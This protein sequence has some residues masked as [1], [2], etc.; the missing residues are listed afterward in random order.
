M[1]VRPSLGVLK[2]KER[3]ES[4]EKDK[5]IQIVWEFKKAIKWF[6]TYLVFVIMFIGVL[7]ST[8]IFWKSFEALLPLVLLFISIFRHKILLPICLSISV[9]FFYF[10]IH[11]KKIDTFI[12]RINLLCTN[13]MAFVILF[14]FLFFFLWFWKIP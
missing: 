1:S 12:V 9:C 2:R 4:R 6:W 11:L 10:F 8:S 3:K 7:W 13:T 5:D 14:L